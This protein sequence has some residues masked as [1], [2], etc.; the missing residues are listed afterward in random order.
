MGNMPSTRKH[1]AAKD[2]VWLSVNTTDADGAT[3]KAVAELAGWDKS[4]NAMPAETF[5]DVNGKI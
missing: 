1:V 5:V 2:L 4:K 3:P